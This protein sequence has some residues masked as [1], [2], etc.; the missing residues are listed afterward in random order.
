MPL[1]G[2][3]SEV[4]ELGQTWPLHETS[5]VIPAFFSS[6][7]EGV[8]RTDERCFFIEAQSLFN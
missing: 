8:R 5:L 2:S 6:E 4:I 1:P 7:E 3:W